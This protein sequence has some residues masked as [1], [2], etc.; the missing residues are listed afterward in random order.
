M[1]PE[2]DSRFHAHW[3]AYYDIM[4]RHGVTPDLAQAILRTNTTVI[5]SVMVH[6]GEAD[7]LICGTF[8]QYLWH[9]KYVE[10]MLTTDELY[11]VGGLS[12]LIMDDG[13]LFVADTQVHPQP[14][15]EQIAETVIG[16]A[17]HV[18]RFGIEPRVALCSNSQFG[19]LDTA[20][21]RL[22][23]AAIKCLD[24]KHCG[25]EYEGEMRLD[26]AIDP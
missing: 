20:T 5:G 9:L 21:G 23:R 24:G 4:K 8:G 11:P 17:R 6:L 7:S 1:N 25:F 26:T 10:Q 22:M 13:P 15:A 18:R 2:S 12:L 3:Q 16:A 19:D 14:T